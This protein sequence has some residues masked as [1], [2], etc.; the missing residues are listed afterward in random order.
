[1][2]K[3]ETRKKIIH[4]HHKDVR[5]KIREVETR[6]KSVAIKIR[7]DRNEKKR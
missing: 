2:Q 4:Q 7:G 6:F 3:K 1:M 5:M